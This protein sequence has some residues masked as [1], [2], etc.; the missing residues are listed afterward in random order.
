MD[1]LKPRLQELGKTEAA[2]AT[3]IGQPKSRVYEM[4]RGDR[5]FQRSE[6]GAA[7]RFLEMSLRELNEHIAGMPPRLLVWKSYLGHRGT[8][9]GTLMVSSASARRAMQFRLDFLRFAERAFAIRMIDDRNAPDYETGNL[10]VIDPDRPFGGDCI[11]LNE[12]HL[13]VGTP[14]VIGRLDEATR[15]T[16]N[17]FQ[18]TNDDL[19]LLRRFAYP[20]A[21]PIMCRIIPHVGGYTVSMSR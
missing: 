19:T 14:A 7:A 12:E 1:W 4:Q 6:L 5:C 10:I 20:Q 15:H 21:W 9:K 16:W 3:A 13:K 8:T 11:F 18:K 2:L 17:I